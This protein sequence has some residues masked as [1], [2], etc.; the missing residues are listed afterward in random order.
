MGREVS[1]K[2]NIEGGG[3]ELF[4]DLKRV[5]A[6]RG[7]GGELRPQFT[8]INLPKKSLAYF[9]FK[10][11]SRQNEVPIKQNLSKN[12]FFFRM[13]PSVNS[14]VAKGM[15]L[16]LL[17]QLFFPKKEFSN[18]KFDLWQQ[19]VKAKFV[20]QLA[21]Y[22]PN[23]TNIALQPLVFFLLVNAIYSFIDQFML[24]LNDEK[25]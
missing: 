5:L 14:E 1:R 25:Y 21:F 6:R 19:V 22:L 3:L 9:S 17:F 4:A 18:T 13:D 2:T 24:Q 10:I 12:F 7:G 20:G 23:T 11:L 15:F 16:L 8:S